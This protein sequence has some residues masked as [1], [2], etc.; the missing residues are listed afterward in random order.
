RD[1]D[2]N[3]DNLRDKYLKENLNIYDKYRKWALICLGVLIII[4]ILIYTSIRFRFWDLPIVIIK[5]FIG[6]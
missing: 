3:Y 4:F 5:W 6:Y 1:D 2:F